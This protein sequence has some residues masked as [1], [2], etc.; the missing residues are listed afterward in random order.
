MA[1]PDDDAVREEVRSSRDRH[2]HF[3][4]AVRGDA[5]FT[6]AH[7]GERHEFRNGI[8]IA[9]QCIRLAVVSDAFLGQVFYRAKASLQRRRVPLL[10]SICHR[11][12][13]M[14][15]QVC[16]GDPVVIQPG[17]YLAHGQVVIDGVAEIEQ[18]VVIFP[19]VTI[20][21]QPPVIFGPR[22][23]PNVQIGT[24]AKVLGPIHIGRA[25]LIGANA[26]VLDNVQAHSLVVGIPAR[27]ISRE[28]DRSDRPGPAGTTDP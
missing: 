27:A 28:T 6:A 3:L 13:M 1:S 24:G 9:M 14:T 4:D 7:R 10:P 8:D 17:L 12:A 23:G 19:W 20:G 15:A 16:I 25:A 22:I 18:G 21:L 5:K 2:P 11:L 26:V